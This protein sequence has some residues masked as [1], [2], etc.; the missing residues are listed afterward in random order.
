M[1]WVTQA[2]QLFQVDKPVHFTNF[3]HCEECAEHDATLLNTTIETIGIKELGNAGWDPICFSNAQGK[4]Y[5]TPAFI[6]LSLNTID[7]EF[8]F[9]QYLFHLSYDGCQSEYYLACSAEQR[10]FIAQFLQYMIETYPEH[11]ELNVCADSALQAYEV[12]AE[13]RD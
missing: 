5:Y 12:W 1:D 13:S 8:Y 4:Q 11:L 6:R 2:K 3:T 10:H 7:Q 9:G